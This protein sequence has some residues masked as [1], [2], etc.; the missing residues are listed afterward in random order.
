[1]AESGWAIEEH[2]RL[3]ERLSDLSDK[4]RDLVARF[5]GLERLDERVRALEQ[6]E[7][8]PLQRLAIQVSEID[9]V[10]DRMDKDGTTRSHEQINAVRE[11]LSVLNSKIDTLTEDVKAARNR[12]TTAVIV[13]AVSVIGNIITGLVIWAV[14]K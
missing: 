7:A 13:G 5:S 3:W 6:L 10:V 8:A 2:R 14:T 12:V 9:H 4:I 1:V 11:A